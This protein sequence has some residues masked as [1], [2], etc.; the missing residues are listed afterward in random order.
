MN[1]V[2]KAWRRYSKARRESQ[3][4]DGWEPDWKRYAR[5]AFVAGY[6]AAVRDAKGKGH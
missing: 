5:K 6:R 1:D 3:K 2:G 4:M